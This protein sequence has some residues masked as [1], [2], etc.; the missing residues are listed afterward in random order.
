MF[1]PV[2]VSN[3]MS[4]I[5][6][7]FASAVLTIAIPITTSWFFLS[8]I[9][10]WSNT[11][12]AKEKAVTLLRKLTNGAASGGL[13]VGVAATTTIQILLT[14]KWH[15]AVTVE[16]AIQWSF[17]VSFLGVGASLFF[18]FKVLSATDSSLVKCPGCQ[19]LWGLLV[20]IAIWFGRA[21][22]QV[23]LARDFGAVSD[24]LPSATSTG[25]F[26]RSFGHVSV[27]MAFFMVA[28]ELFAICMFLGFDRI[29]GGSVPGNEVSRSR[30]WVAV[31]N[32]SLMVVSAAISS[33]AAS[34]L[35]FNDQPVRAAVARVAADIDLLPESACT[36]SKT[37]NTK[38]IVF[39]SDEREQALVFRV[40]DDLGRPDWINQVG[41][42]RLPVVEWTEKDYVKVMPAL[43]YIDR[44][45]KLTAES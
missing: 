28:V 16:D 24:K 2:E 35:A 40:P 38:K 43:I 25:I 3:L 29:F 32:A 26:L 37:D 9:K 10:R 39:R 44:N 30:G 34:V 42:D 19:W 33:S 8:G 6:K 27:A 22:T 45:C 13:T 12:N 21:R 17:L 20:L 1:F 5:L 31:F 15:Q 18:N 4:I 7:I 41:N 11:V 23:D 36:G 14:S